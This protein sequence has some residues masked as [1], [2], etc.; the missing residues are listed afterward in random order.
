MISVITETDKPYT[1]PRF[2]IEHER[3][4]KIKGFYCAYTNT[5]TSEP[6]PVDKITELDYIVPSERNEMAF[7]PAIED[8]RS[9]A[10]WALEMGFCYLITVRVQADYSTYPVGA[11]DTDF[12]KLHGNLINSAYTRR[13]IEIYNLGSKKYIDDQLDKAIFV[14]NTPASHHAAYGH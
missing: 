3:H 12:W 6:V 5:A 4:D 14:H 1:F 13:A 2:L 8:I 9:W 10:Y 7:V 11:Y